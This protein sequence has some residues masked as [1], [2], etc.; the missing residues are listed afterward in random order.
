MASTLAGRH[1]TSRMHVPVLGL[2]RE[3]PWGSATRRSSFDG[4]YDVFV[5]FCLLALIALVVFGG[6]WLFLARVTAV[7]PVS[8]R[9]A[10]AELGGC[11]RAES[12][13]NDAVVVDENR[14]DGPTLTR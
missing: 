10:C 14:T 2:R 3:R 6:A 7:L 12:D 13:S 8:P 4:F 11:V 1:A 9:V 5:V